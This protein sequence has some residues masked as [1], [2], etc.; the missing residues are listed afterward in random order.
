MRLPSLRRSNQTNDL[1]SNPE[2]SEQENKEAS[3]H[4]MTP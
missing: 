3:E 4:R 2:D 1:S